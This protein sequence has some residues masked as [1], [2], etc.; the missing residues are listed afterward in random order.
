MWGT[1]KIGNAKDFPQILQAL[2]FQGDI[3]LLENPDSADAAENNG[4]QA[5]Y[6]NGTPPA[7]RRVTAIPAKRL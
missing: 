2:N 1:N 5:N 7:R 4:L 3:F 6:A